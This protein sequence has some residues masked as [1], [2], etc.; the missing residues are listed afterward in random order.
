M[1]VM[2]WFVQFW[3]VAAD[4]YKLHVLLKS[5]GRQ[6]Q[7]FMSHNTLANPPPEKHSH[8]RENHMEDVQ[9]DT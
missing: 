6:Q 8:K 7:K 9:P 2:F 3:I 4:S 1:R 5:E